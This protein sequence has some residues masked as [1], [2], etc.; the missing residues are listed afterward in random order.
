ML[1]PDFANGLST[2]RLEWF[3]AAMEGEANLEWSLAPGQILVEGLGD[4]VL[5]GGCLSLIVA[6]LDTPY[7]Y[8]VDDGIWFWEDVSEPTYR[9]DRMLTTLRLSGRLDRLQGVMI[10]Q[11]K[12]CGG[13]E[14]SELQNLIADF[15]TGHG[16]PVAQELPFGHHGDNLLLPIGARVVLDTHLRSIRFPEPFVQIQRV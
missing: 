13:A 14:P 6:L 1:N 15:F 3:L 9:I 16:I 2:A 7:D 12:D 5:F 4:G 11:L 8:W 10:G